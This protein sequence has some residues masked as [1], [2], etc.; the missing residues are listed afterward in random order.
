MHTRANHIRAQNLFDD[1][2]VDGDSSPFGEQCDGHN[3]THTLGAQEKKINKLVSKPTRLMDDYTL[4]H[5]QH[6][7]SQEM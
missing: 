7:V 2:L 6:M 1:N 5:T 3:H 4:Q